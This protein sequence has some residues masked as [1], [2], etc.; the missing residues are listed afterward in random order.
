MKKRFEKLDKL[1]KQYE[2]LWK[3]SAFTSIS[4]SR[5]KQ[6]P[7]IANWLESLSD[8]D[9]DQL[10]ISNSEL[11]NSAQKYFPDA[12]ELTRL[13]SFP[14]SKSSD[15][16]A[17][18]PFWDKDIP[19]RKVEQIKAFTL[20]LLPT[21]EPI[22]E[23]CC[24]KQH[25]GRLISEVSEQKVCGIEIDPKLIEQAQALTKKR[26]VESR[27]TIHRCDVLNDS[28][29]CV[30]PE[31]HQIALHACGGLHVSMLK[32]SVTLTA[33]RISFSPCC[34]HRFNDADCYQPLSKQACLSELS[35]NTQ[36]LRLATRQC[37]IASAA[38]TRKRKQMQAWRLGFD[39]L[40]RDIRSVDEYLPC[41]SLSVKVLHEGFEAFCSKLSEIK[42]I[43]L[44]ASVDFAHY[45]LLGRTRFKVYERIELARMLFR[46][47]LEVW[48]VLDRAI[49]LEE[50]GYQCNISIFCDDKTSPRNL[51]VDAYRSESFT[52]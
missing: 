36:D 2:P 41:P 35:L 29:A 3:P 21:T 50:N 43:E 32:H 30:N 18:P 24:G 7:E 33:P 19:G 34:Y 13:I 48:L 6:F 52:V 31:D 49:Y 17:F 51:L 44:P 16:I 46:R 39:A 45:E 28:L 27:M 25:L 5:F 9:I 47:A 14:V 26:N 4:D 12:K 42:Q 15:N 8:S 1:L 20:S 11:L 23:W 38:E 37:N 40:Q 22:S 10:Q